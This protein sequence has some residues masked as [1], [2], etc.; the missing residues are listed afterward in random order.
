M[1]TSKVFTEAVEMKGL[2]LLPVTILPACLFLAAIAAHSA[3]NGSCDAGSCPL[4]LWVPA[5]T[6]CCCCVPFIRCAGTARPERCI[7]ND[8]AEPSE[9]ARR[10]WERY[11]A[12]LGDGAGEGGKSGWV[13]ALV[14]VAEVTMFPNHC[15]GLGRS[16]LAKTVVTVAGAPEYLQKKK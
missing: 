2:V 3:S 5:H 10:C 1:C 9:W 11:G 15:S 8:S 16:L 6:D 4:A 7:R 12:R 13:S 14:A